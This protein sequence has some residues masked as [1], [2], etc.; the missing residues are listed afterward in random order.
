MS[1]IVSWVISLLVVGLI[2]VFVLG[3]LSLRQLP[4]TERPRTR[5]LNRYGE[6][7]GSVENPDYHVGAGADIVPDPALDL[8]EQS[9][10]ETLPT[11]TDIADQQPE[12]DREPRAVG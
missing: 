2:V 1:G 8:A 10:T 7:I 4:T 3:I 9:G 11:P 12:A 6:L 5:T